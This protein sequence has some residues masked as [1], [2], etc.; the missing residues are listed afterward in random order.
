M[1]DRENFF[2]YDNEPR[3]ARRAGLEPL[4]YS[5][6]QYAGV[7]PAPGRRRRCACGV[8]HAFVFFR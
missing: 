1:L 8:L 2:V 3:D 5:G 4:R 7:R 6:T